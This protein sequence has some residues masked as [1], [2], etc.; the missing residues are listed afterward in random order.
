MTDRQ[1]SEAATDD[2]AVKLGPKIV[3]IYPS[4]EEAQAAKDWYERTFGDVNGLTVEEITR[5]D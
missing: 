4:E 5:D 3:T 1:P 2:W